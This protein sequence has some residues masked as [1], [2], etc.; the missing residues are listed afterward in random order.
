MNQYL[1]RNEVLPKNFGTHV[2]RLSQQLKT[3]SLAD[4]SAIYADLNR[5]R[6]QV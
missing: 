4:R 6:N 3:A 5:K 1:S 2:E